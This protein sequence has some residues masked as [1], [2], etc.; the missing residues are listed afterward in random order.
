MSPWIA[1]VMVAVLVLGGMTAGWVYLIHRACSGHVTATVAASPSIAPIL[2]HINEQ[3]AATHPAVA[4][5]CVFANIEAKDSALMATALG[6]DWDPQANGPAPDVWVPESSVWIRQASVNLNAERMMPDRQPSLAR[7]P[8]V[9]AMPKDMATALGWPDSFPFDW[10]DLAKDAAVPAFWSTHGK[11]WGRFQFA[12]TDPTTSTA[13]LL[14]LMAIADG[15]N[16]GQVDPSEQRG[17][18]DV[19][20][21]MHSYLGDSGDV[22]SGL[23]KADGASTNAAMGYISAFPAL[24]QNVIDYNRTDPK[25]P[26]VALYPSSGSYDADHPYLILNAPWSTG[27]GKN[28]AAAFLHFAR[29]AQARAQFLAAG[30]RDPN[31]K[32]G[33]DLTQANGVT[34]TDLPLP[35]AVLV[36]DSVEETLTTWTA[37]TRETNLLLVLDV[38]GSM[39]GI[40]AGVGKSRLTLAKAAAVTA[41]QKFDGQASVGLW[42]FSTGLVGNRDY[43]KVVPLGALGDTMPD[44]LTRQQDMIAA[45][46]GLSAGGNT[47]LYDTIA[48][49]QADVVAHFKPG[50]ANLV[51]LM[52]DGQNQDDTGGLDLQQLKLKLEKVQAGGENVPVVTIGYGKDADYTT[53]QDISRTSGTTSLSSKTSFDINQVLLAALFGAV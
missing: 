32:G 35:R 18:L 4:G 1:I 36:P 31:R 28:A 3:W 27:A 52:T 8:T 22:L 9:V 5:T 21:T 17:V 50:A 34:P 38:S 46:N 20:Q 10:P 6:N 11:P 30:F 7:T 15:N 48:A 42:V 2:G 40:V 37:V 45:I 25:E 39:N 26:L 16:D 47:G 19:K 43:R 12:M 53:L 44:G 49:A 14:S 33:T 13:G 41:V 24:E 23:S 51:V 29:A